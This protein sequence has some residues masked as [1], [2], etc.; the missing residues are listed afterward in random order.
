MDIIQ[1][2]TALR[3]QI[4]AQRKA[5]SPEQIAQKSSQIISKIIETSEYKKSEC[6]YAY[7]PI[8]GEADMTLLIEKAWRD[9]KRVAV[10]RVAGKELIF[11]YIKS[12]DELDMG[13]FGIREP[14]DGLEEAS[15]EDA[16]LIIP[17]VVFDKSGHRIGYG[18]GFY[19]RYLEAHTRHLIVAPAYDFQVK[20]KIITQEH[21][22]SVDMVICDSERS[23]Y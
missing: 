9:G 13:S 11:Y 17:G 18:G 19:D 1:E 16:L 3:K 14:K 20:D 6:I 2:K 10:P 8:R 21:D 15:C 23:R 22:I 7:M 12:F 4:L 5:L